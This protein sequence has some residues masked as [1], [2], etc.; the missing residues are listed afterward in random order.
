MTS[1]Y[2]RKRRAKLFIQQG[3]LC[4]WCKVQMV[5]YPP[6]RKR[7][8]MPLDMCTIDHLRDRF[9]PNRR[10]CNPRGEQRLVAACWECNNR[11]GAERAASVSKRTLWRRSGRYPQQDGGAQA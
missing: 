7:K 11:R 2:I 1:G 9:D 3:G 8:A 5:E 10:E 4:F 6:K